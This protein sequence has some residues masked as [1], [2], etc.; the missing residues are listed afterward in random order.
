M[1]KVLARISGFQSVVYSSS[2][3]GLLK[4]KLA[5]LYDRDKLDPKLK[6][7]YSCPPEEN[8]TINF[9]P[10]TVLG[11][12]WDNCYDFKDQWKAFK[13]EVQAASKEDREGPSAEEMVKG[14]EKNLRL[15]IE[16]DI[17]PVLGDQV[18]G[19][20]AEVNSSGGFPLPKL[21]FFVKM[22]GRL[23]AEKIMDTLVSNRP[24]VFQKEVYEEIPINY[25]SLPLGVDIEPAYSFLGDYL[26]L[27]TSR[28][29][30]KSA[31]DSFKNPSVLSLAS[32]DRF[33]KVNGGLTD[34][35]N[36]V[37]FLQLDDIMSNTRTIIN[38]VTTQMM[39]KAGQDRAFQEGMI[40][41]LADV[42]KKIA[43]E[44][45]EQK[46]FNND[47]KSAKEKLKTLQAQGLDVTQ[48]MIT[49]DR[50]EKQIEA[51]QDTIKTSKTDQDELEDTVLNF[52]KEKADPELIKFY[53]DQALMPF[54]D[55]LKSFKT[56]GS[57]MVLSE[58]TIE[59]TAV[60]EVGE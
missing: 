32:S 22:N 10:H 52:K 35:N 30:I 45:S 28:G 38:W 14:L 47:L 55:G 17:L 27:A 8:R 16:K 48:T 39:T 12:K 20:L 54:L 33:K 51:K 60:I 34:K 26:L 46:K 6:E 1:D 37:I 18:G 59:M 11:Y 31:V 42:K 19:Y 13:E 29:V 3:A 40:K 41:R 56:L 58:G 7:M 49:I 44:E 2:S 53:V 36:S 21:L 23:A 4:L 9:V 57:R 24:V 43:E 15:S 25:V 5:V 50:L